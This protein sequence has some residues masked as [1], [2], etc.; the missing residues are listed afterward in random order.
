MHS[1]PIGLK[2][3]LGHEVAKKTKR[4]DVTTRDEHD[5]LNPEEEGQ[6]G[7]ALGCREIVLIYTAEEQEQMVDSLHAV[8]AQVPARLFP[9]RLSVV[10]FPI[11]S[12]EKEQEI[13]HRQ[14]LHFLQMN[15]L[16]PHP[17]QIG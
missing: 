14:Q 9:Q 13:I 6:K 7:R 15:L 1:T 11:T 17:L 4:R 12:E 2:L 16:F 10:L 3:I 5:R 8:L